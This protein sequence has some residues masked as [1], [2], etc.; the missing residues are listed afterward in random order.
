MYIDVCVGVLAGSLKIER[1]RERERERESNAH[2]FPTCRL[3][4]R[5]SCN[6]TF[7]SVLPPPPPPRLQGEGRR[8]ATGDWRGWVAADGRPARRCSAAASHPQRSSSGQVAFDLGHKWSNSSIARPCGSHTH[9]SPRSLTRRPRRRERRPCTWR[10]EE[11]TR[12]RRRRWWRG[13]QTST[14]R[15]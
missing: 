10:L 15:M 9:Q 1:E 5:I 8:S 4:C 7:A 11:A 6:Q 3:Q 14:P 2:S 12:R 13:G